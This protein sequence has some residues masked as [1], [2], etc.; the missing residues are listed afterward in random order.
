MVETLKQEATRLLADVPEEYVFR[1]CNGHILR[2]MKELGDELKTMSN[3]SYAFHVNTEKNDFT[4]WVGDII[5]D[6][7]LVKDLQK[8]PNQAQAARLVA[9]RISILSKRLA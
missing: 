3:E 1:C 7:R 5:K 9:S 2:N 8:S 6:G 4:N